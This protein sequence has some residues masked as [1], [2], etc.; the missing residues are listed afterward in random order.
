MKRR[1]MNLFVACP[2]GRTFNTFFDDKN[3]QLAQTLF[4]VTWNP[5]DRNLTDE[6]VTTLAAGCDV[7]MSSWGSPAPN[8]KLLDASPSLRVIAHLGTSTEHMR[9]DECLRRGINV[10][11]GEEFY[12][13]SAAEGTL[14]YILASLRSIPEFSLR[15]K[16]K[17][18][19]KHKWDSCRGLMGKTV[20]IYNY[21]SI[22]RWLVRLLTPFGVSIIAY[23]KEKINDVGVTQV[24]KTRLF[25]SSDIICVYSPSVGDG[26]KEIGNSLLNIIK[27][28]AI[29]LDVSVSGVVDREAL[30]D[31]LIRKNFT[32]VLDVFEKEPPDKD[33][34]LI[35]HHN[36]LPMPHM[37]GPSLD[38]RKLITQELLL[39]AAEFCSEKSKVVF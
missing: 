20:G 38:V 34:E 2:R 22:A 17:G 23:D 35:A 4:E 11:S 14:S 18:E 13:R 26:Y 15:L 28:G 27:T 30:L 1:T 10:L 16:Y 21:G 24:S 31:A 19:W 8:D 9:K 5:F 36:V 7:Y 33:D 12:A 37:A 3:L 6:E 39:K 29:F 32:A 25:S